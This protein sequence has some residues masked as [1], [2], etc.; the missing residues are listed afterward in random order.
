MVPLNRL[1]QV[2]DTRM[3]SEEKVRKEN[4]ER[5]RATTNIFNLDSSVI[6]HCR[7]PHPRE[8]GH[9]VGDSVSGE[10]GLANERC[11]GGFDVQSSR[12]HY[13]PVLPERAHRPEENK[14]SHPNPPR[15]GQGHTP[16]DCVLRARERL[17][18]PPTTQLRLRAAVPGA[19]AAARCFLARQ[20][21]DVPRAGT[22]GEIAATETESVTAFRKIKPTRDFQ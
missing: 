18:A 9:S 13:L 2:I 15:R 21:G 22:R 12:L 4:I 16:N 19:E 3:H 8:L 14:R 7:A 6:A 1:L 20:R 5:L 10:I 17:A 11:P